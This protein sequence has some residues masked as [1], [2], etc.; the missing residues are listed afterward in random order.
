MVV[1]RVPTRLWHGC[2]NL[3]DIDPVSAV[4]L[5]LNYAYDGDKIVVALVLVGVVGR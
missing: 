1:G 2:G 3:V 5:H 4:D